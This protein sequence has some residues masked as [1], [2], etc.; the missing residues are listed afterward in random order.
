MSTS[1]A[2]RRW[3]GRLAGLAIS[4]V[5][6]VIVI[7]TVDVAE[8]FEILRR[9]EPL[10]LVLVLAVIAAQVAVRGWRWR[11]LLPHR[12]DGS[13]VPLRRTF[14]PMLIGYLGNI[15]LP[16]RLGEAI[17]SFLVARRETLVPLEAFGAT[18]LE[19]L[20]D[21]VVLA[22]IGLAAAVAL[23]AEWWIVAIGLVAGVGGVLVLAL[24][25]VLGFG[26]LVD[27]GRWVLER[28]RLAHR[29]ERL[30]GWAGSFAV[31]VD[32]GRD[33]PRLLGASGVSVVAWILDASIFYLVGRSLGLELAIA[34]AVLIGAVAVLA[35]AVP[36]APGYVGTF[37]L[38]ATSTAVALGVPREEAL[39]LA[40]LVH[41]ITVIP[42]AIAGAIALI[43]SGANLGRIAAEAERAE[44]A[45][46]PAE[47]SARPAS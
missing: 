23:G 6:I 10:Y 32:R 36:A 16:A 22:L 13:A 20:I 33:V 37:E 46:A 5:A 47:G 1:S 11:M 24:L 12:P 18:M 43:M 26:R 4:L 44:D 28:L 27:V 40:V 25:V 39:A 19:R 21:V 38:A 17:R 29:L 30:L 45:H 8:T 7:S 15:V 41:M 9:A 14:S 34:E 42:V 35:T 3:G 2:T 31:G